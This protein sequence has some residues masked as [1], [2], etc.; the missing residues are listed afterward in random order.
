MSDKAK[1]GRTLSSGSAVLFAGGMPDA[2]GFGDR[3]DEPVLEIQVLS[4]VVP[5]DGVDIS[6]GISASVEDRTGQPEDAEPPEPVGRPVVGSTLVGLGVVGAVAAAALP[7][8]G[9]HDLPELHGLALSQSWLLWLMAAVAGAMVVGVVAL[10]RPRRAVRWWG[11]ALALG[12]AVLSGWSVTELPQET[13]IGVGPGLC[14]VALVILAAGHV[15]SALSREVA[16]DW[17]WRPAGVAAA[18]VV[19]VLVAAGLSTAGLVHA[20]DVD[21]TTSDSPMVALAGSAPAAVDKSLWSRGAR[22]YD[23]AGSVALVVGE[24]QRGE[25]QLP[26]VSVLDLRTG[27]ERWHHYERGWKVREATLT[28]DGSTALVVVDTVVR[29]EAIGFDAATGV[30][31]W[32]QRLAISVNCRYPGSDEISPVGGCAGELVTGDG[33]LYVSAVGRNSVLPVTYLAAATGRKWPIHLAP[34]C[35][36]RGAGADAGGVYVLEQCVSAGFPEAHLVSETA[37]AYTLSGIERWATPLALVKGTVAGVFGPVFV[38]G[39]VVSFQQEQRYAALNAAN[40]EQL[41]TTTDGFEPETVVTD[42]THLAWSTGI[43]VIM[44]DLHTGTFRWSQEWEFPE[45]AD[46][47]LIANGRLYLIQHTVGPNPYTCAEHATLLT[48][49]ATNGKTEHA[50]RLPGGAGNDCGPDVEDRSYLSG[51]LM[52]ITTAN[53]ITV[54][55]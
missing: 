9:E 54:L 33:L 1:T 21:A 37:V 45:E 35:R 31:R 4:D 23:V 16:P 6:S 7:W 53:T 2:T 26:G 28:Q 20:R 50:N 13:S 36:L 15:V 39:D 14:C 12:G 51:P 44:L 22:V 55:N 3:D 30:I 32:R 29:S 11:A 40:G 41:W 48:L 27:A 24:R 42:G 19:A 49:D 38:R 17:R 25:I 46:L 47:P 10:A 43:Q 8:S 52:I 5:L 34:G 18:A